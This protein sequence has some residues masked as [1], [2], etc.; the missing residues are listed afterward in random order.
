DLT[1]ETTIKILEDLKAGRPPAKL[2]PQSSR[3]TSEPMTG[4]TTL[5]S[6]PTGPGFGLQ[7]G[8]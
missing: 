3:Q 5:T 2:G 8:L 1:P 6:E 4:L 7:Q